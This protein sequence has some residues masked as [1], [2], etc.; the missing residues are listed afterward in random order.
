M[1]CDKCN[2]FVYGDTCSCGTPHIAKV[3]IVGGIAVILLAAA[4]YWYFSPK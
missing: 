3:L 1:I 2:D 4:A